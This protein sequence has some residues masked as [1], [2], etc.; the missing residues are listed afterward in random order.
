MVVERSVRT[1]LQ[2]G[3]LRAVLR[4]TSQALPESLAIDG[5]AVACAAD[6]PQE[7]VLFG[8]AGILAADSQGD[9]LVG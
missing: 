1:A 6:A 9:G 8:G 3:P 4:D 2:G 7:G 5:E